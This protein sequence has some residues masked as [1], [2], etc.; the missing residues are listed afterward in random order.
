MT[1]L[2]D[3]SRFQK[4][5]FTLDLD[6]AATYV[7]TFRG[8]CVR[9]VSPVITRAFL[10]RKVILTKCDDHWNAVHVSQVPGEDYN[11]GMETPCLIL[12]EFMPEFLEYLTDSELYENETTLAKST[13]GEIMRSL[14]D[15]L[16]GQEA[17]WTLWEKQLDEPDDI[18]EIYGGLSEEN[19]S[20]VELYSP[21]RLV[22]EAQ[23]RGL[24]ASLSID[25]VTGY[26][27][28]QKDQQEW[29]R[30]ELRRRRPRLLTTTPPCTK[31]SPLQNIRPH[32]ERL[33]E[34]LPEAKR[35]LNFSM[36][37]QEEQL[38]RGGDGLH[39][40]PDTATSWLLPKVQ[41]YL[42]HEQ[43][44]LVKSH[45]CRFGLKVGE[46]GL[47]RKATLF[48]TTNDEIAI[49]LQRLCNCQQPHESL[50]GGLPHRAQEYPPALVRAIIDGLVQSWVN[51]QKGRP[52]RLP[53]TGD[54]NQWVD[55]LRPREWQ[56]WR[57]FN[58]DA[59]LVLR[60][61]LQ[62]QVPLQGPDHR[63]LRWT[64]VKG[65]LDGKWIQ[66]EQGSSGKISP[67]EVSY[68]FVVILYTHPELT[69]SFAESSGLT[70]AEK[71][72]ILR[73]HV[74]LGHPGVKEFVR[75]LKAAGSRNDVVQYVL[76]EFTCEGCLKEKRQ[77]TRLPASAPRTYDFNVVLGIDLLFVY[78]I[79]HTTE[80]PILNVTCLGTL[81][82]T[83]SMVHP[84][85]RGL[86]LVWSKFLSVWLRTFG[87]PSFVLMDQ[88]L[89][90]QGHFISML[91]SHGIQPLLIDRDAPYQNGVTER[92]GGLFKEVYYRTRELKQLATIE[93]VQDLVHEVSWAL[94][95]MTNRSGYSPAQRVFGKQ[96]SLGLDLLS[97]ARQC[98]YSMTTDD[99]WSRSE[100]IRKAA[101]QALMDVDAKER[102]QRAIRARPR[103]AREDH[104]FKEGDPV[105]VWRQG[106]RG[107][108]AKV[109]PC[110]VVLQR[111]DTVWVTRRGELW[112]CNKSQVFEM[113]CLEKQGLEVIEAD[114]LKAKERLRFHPEKL[115]YTD[116]TKEG[117]PPDDLEIIEQ[118]PRQAPPTPAAAETARQAT[119]HTARQQAL[120]PHTVYR[121]VPGTPRGPPE[122]LR[123][124]NPSTPAPGALG[125]LAPGTPARQSKQPA[126]PVA[127][128][129]RDRARSPA[130]AAPARV[131][132]D[133][134]IDSS[135]AK[136]QESQPMASASKQASAVT[137]AAADQPQSAAAE[138]EEGNDADE[139]WKASLENRKAHQDVP[140]PSSGH[141]GVLKMWKRHDFSAKRYRGSNSKG[142]LWTD[143]VRRVTYDIDTNR[144]I[145]DI[146]ITPEMPIH[147]A[148]DKLPE[149]VINILTV[150]V[151][152]AIPEHPDPGENYKEPLYGPNEVVD[153][154]EAPEEDARLVDT[155]MKRSLEGAA[156]DQRAPQRSRIF[157]QWRADD[158]TEW[159][160]KAM[161]PVVANQRDLQV[162]HK[163]MKNDTYYNHYLQEESSLSYLTKQSG[164]ELNEKKLN[165]AEKKLFAEAKTKEIDNLIGSNAIEMITDQEQIRWVHDKYSHR[166][167][168]SRFIIT[169]K[170]GEVGE[171]WKAKAR[172]ILLGHRDPDS[173]QLERFAPT[174]SSTTVMLALQILSSLQ[175]HLF[176]MDVSSA[177]G[178]SDP[179]ERE[180]GPLY[181]SMPPSGI[182]GYGQQTLIR[183]LTAVYGLVNAP[184]VWRRTVRRKLLTLGY[185]ESVFDPCLYYLKPTEEEMAGKK[186][187]VAGIVLLD[188]DDF[189]QGGNARHQ[190][191]MNQLRTQLK[192]GKWKDVFDS[193]AD[194]IGRTLHQ[195]PTF[196]IQVSMK[197]FIQEKLRPVTLTKERMKQKQELLDEK[198]ISW[199]RGVG[200]SLLW[201]GKEGRPDVGAACA[202]SMSWPSTGPTVEHIL[203]AN[204]T[205]A[206]LKQTMDTIIRIMPI[207]AEESI[208]M[209]VADASMANVEN[210]SQGGFVLALA[211]ESIMKGQAADFSLNSW[212]SHKL[213][214]VVKA[215][216]GSEALAMD[217]ALAEVEWIRALWH[218]LLDPSSCVLDGSRLGDTESAM[219]VRLPEHN[220]DFEIA[221]IR[222]KDDGTGAHV[223]DAKALFDLLS[224]RSGNAGQCRRAQID[225]AVICISARLLKVKTY[226]VPGSQMLADPLTKRCGNSMLMRQ[227]MKSAQFS[228][229]KEPGS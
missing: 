214:R 229:V 212:R 161:F 184:A 19:D 202:M 61:P 199:L 194:Y 209:T 109:G 224:R 97:D 135:K 155:G 123:T 111:G 64:W 211:H 204:K 219:V 45:L 222:V 13:K 31:F 137:P 74:N 216:L 158:L 72:M 57:S 6:Q 71:Q 164:K 182:P 149:G 167:M 120:D 138:E 77:P 91:E 213:K 221:S 102:V 227:V 175:F 156:T 22:E 26:D 41:N 21:P 76:K 16:G 168:P 143:V 42:Q 33:M 134:V 139:L 133:E 79:S 126:T 67:F 12:Y 40:H 20:V 128:Q 82:S 86:E 205:V 200:G 53:D 69:W 101:R 75:L 93:E 46:G 1:S 166:I 63:C 223:T 95:T 228:L 11:L 98:E 148:H 36:D 100:E 27:M 96:P 130:K 183:V 84:T 122:G 159:G 104:H 142:P 176:I 25:L 154:P 191:L 121:K 112:K 140:E 30:Q 116:V 108:V 146:A 50:I 23:K 39:E 185:E 17:Y 192:F 152:K 35:H 37:M 196:E 178:Q 44:V 68:P 147:R 151:Y 157:G 32:P 217:D 119:R 160:S 24:K 58:D 170:T 153:P 186:L 7:T 218:E 174:P 145:Q 89:E 113:G 115:G 180:Q 179:V 28:N 87:A 43:V 83:F 47:N 215:T 106:R 103:R 66:F 188:V 34:E 88:G 78:G 144:K 124:P 51:T 48:A 198:E 59:I 80:H 8:E 189:C 5:M 110:F 203:M 132:I 18:A 65:V 181:A 4:V 73:A 90:F 162:F 125:T 220:E 9:G 15:L 62:H 49:N 150:L 29:V 85:R 60:K 117:D 173:L 195:L 55:E 127:T 187:F 201:V 92:R 99:A 197:R 105:S 136:P 206:E 14:D 226:W 177:F 70:A 54:L 171:Q 81:Y 107:N 2:R 131:V 38:S 129:R 163:V 210:K 94:Q 114:L 10:S 207:P 118:A 208:W 225:V 141:P 190:E 56:Q 172:W 193:S 165:D 169:K 3:D 52:K